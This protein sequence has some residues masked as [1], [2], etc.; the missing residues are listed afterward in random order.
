MNEMARSQCRPVPHPTDSP[1][2][3]ICDFCL[4]GGIK[5]RLIGGTAIDAKDLGNGVQIIL[6]RISEDKKNRALDHWI[7]RCEWITEHEGDY[8]QE[9]NNLDNLISLYSLQGI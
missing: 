6:K 8:Y 4:F 1:D 5:E 9:Q 2:L 7:G 3:A